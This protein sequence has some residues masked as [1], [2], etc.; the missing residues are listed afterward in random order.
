MATITID[1]AEMLEIYYNGDDIISDTIRDIGRW[2]TYHDL[3][4]KYNGKIYKTNYSRGSTEYQS[5]QPW[6]YDTVVK[7]YEVH[8]VEKLVKVYETVVD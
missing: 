4:F 5:Q 1:K 8:E 2:E 7:C 6:E 3:I